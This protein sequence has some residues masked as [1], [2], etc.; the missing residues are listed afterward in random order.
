MNNARR[1]RGLHT[2]GMRLLA[3]G[4]AVLGAAVFA[5]PLLAVRSSSNKD[6]LSDAG[7]DGGVAP[8]GNNGVIEVRRDAGTRTEIKQDGTQV[9]HVGD[10]IGI[11]R[12]YD[13][14]GG[15]AGTVQPGPSVAELQAQ[16]AGLQLQQRALQD[17]VVAAENQSQQLQQL[18]QA[19]D[20]LSQ[21][22]AQLASRQ[23]QRDQAAAE[24]A[25]Q[26]LQSQHAIDGLGA[27]MDA[28][29][30]GNDDVG[31]A[32]DTADQ[33]FTPQARRDLA[34]ARDAI[35]NKNLAQA[36]AL[37]QTAIGDAQAGR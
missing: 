33:S 4:V 23:A 37:M 25:A 5:V 17:R 32:L 8:D 13:S 14:V 18:Q 6:G 24:S 7:V 20:Q 34:A 29:A 1:A 22:N 19:N 15:D 12:N 28:M 31:N 9:I 2:S 36:R 27:A 35:A 10:P 30:S 11:L 3:A 26:Q 21:L 16:I